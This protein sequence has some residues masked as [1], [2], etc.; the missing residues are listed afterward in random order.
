MSSTSSTEKKP[1]TRSATEA[2]ASRY[3][4]L[5][6]LPSFPVLLIY[7]GL[8]SLALSIISRGVAVAGAVS[9]IEVF[10]VLVLSAV[11]ISSAIRVVDRKTIATLRRSQAL[12]LAGELLWVP[13]AAV[14]AVCSLASGSPNPLTNAVLFGAFICA[15][16]EFLIIEGAFQKNVPVSLGLAAIHPVSTLLVIRF[17]ELTAHLDAAAAS[18]GAVALVLLVAF[19]LMMRQRKTSVGHD[20][21][22]LFQAFMKTWAA[23]DADELERIISDHSEE[24]DVTTKVLRFKTKSGDIFLVLPG[25]HPGPFHPVGSYDLP[26]V[27]SR[28]FRDLGPVMTL[29]RPG[30][31]EHN[32]ATREETSKYAAS[33]SELARNTT[34]NGGGELRGPEHAKVGKATVSASAFSNDLLMTVSFAPLGS[35]DIDTQVEADLAKPA[36]R[37]G[38]DLSVIDAHNS[39]NPNLETPDTDDPG[40]KRLF[41]A[42]RALRP[43]ELT[44]AYSH[45]SE[46]GFGGRGDLTENGM[47]LFM[48]KNRDTKSVLILADANNSI[49]ELRAKI[50]S[51]LKSSGYDLIEF[52]TSDSHNLA[53]RGLTVER[54]YEA[55][56][57][58]TP[59]S[60]IAELAVSLAKRAEARL[61][62]ALYGSAKTKTKVRVFG[63]KALEEFAA[64]TQASS[65]FARRYFRLAG[66][67]AVVLLLVSLFF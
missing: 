6:T 5:F 19:P 4:H 66:G 21:L 56:G 62:P 3:R 28:S 36:S 13:I 49:P 18:S 41:E 38:F 12:L 61:S 43:D 32:L 63:P 47:A 2:L 14:G 65:T 8:T 51:A 15:G 39:I 60:S 25:V 42:V 45:S 35:D 31:H 27:I 23:G 26:G 67:A 55:L 9:F 20:S 30:G 46:V 22:S 58:A 44:V 16:F 40:W 17:S 50:E 57:E 11:A 59:L 37:V 1:R 48:V 53:A 54:G 24:A 64:I 10:A 34:S 52:C 33:V 29:H 7:G